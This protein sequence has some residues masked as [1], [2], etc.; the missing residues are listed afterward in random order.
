MKYLRGSEWVRWDL[1]I[2]TPCS[3]LNNQFG[4]DWDIYVR[5]L[6]NKAIENDIKVIGITDYF[7]IDGYKKLK[8]EY[9]NKDE[10]LKIIFENEIKEDPD[11][12]EKVKNIL[13]LPNIEFRLENEIYYSKDG[14]NVDNKKLQ[15]HIIFDNLVSIEN[16]EENFLQQLKFKAIATCRDGIDER[17]FTHNNLIELGQY[18][19][20]CQK[21]FEHMNDFQAGLNCAAV[22]LNT[23]INILEQNKNLFKNKYRLLVVEDDITNIKWGDQCHMTRKVIYSVAHGIFSSNQRT[24]DWGLAESTEKEFSSLKP[25]LWGSDAHNFDK[26]FNPDNMKYCWIKANPTFT[27]LMQVFYSPK[28][29]VFIGIEPPKLNVYNRNITQFIDRV[30]IRKKVGAINPEVWFSANMPFN[31]GLTAII[32]NKGSGKSALS[33][34]LGYLCNSKNMKFASFLNNER[35]RKENKLFSDDY[36]ANIKWQDGHNEYVSSLTP[37]KSQYEVQHAQ[38]LPQRYIENVCNNLD[39]EFQTEIDNVIFSYIDKKDRGNAHSLK[40]LIFERSSL[41]IAKIQDIKNQIENLN[42]KIMQLENKQTKIYRK[43]INDK[44]AYLQEE[45]KRTIENEPRK[46][47]KPNETNDSEF[48]TEIIRIE[49]LM[50]K[51]DQEIYYYNEQISSISSQIVDLKELHRQIDDFLEKYDQI[52]Q[53]IENARGIYSFSENELSIKLDI[54]FSGIDSKIEK[55]QKQKDDLNRL[56]SMIFDINSVNINMQ[57]TKNEIDKLV[58]KTYSLY[59][60]NAILLKYKI[61]LNNRTTVEQQKYQKYLDDYK[62]WQKKIE[63]IQKGSDMEQG[64]DWYNLEMEYVD[65]K[66]DTEIKLL[67]EK[68]LNLVLD[69]YNQIRETVSLYKDIYS[70]VQEKLQAILHDIDDQITFSTDIVTINNLGNQVLNYINQRVS[71]DFQGIA[72]GTSFIDQ[73]IRSTD[74]NNSDSL[75]TFVNQIY[76]ATT[77]D[78]DKID[79]L[80]KERLQFNNFISSLSY[81]K[82][83]YTLKMGQKSLNELSPGERGIVLLVFYLALEKS[84]CPL[85][86]DQPEDNLDNE[87][88]FTKLVPCICKAKTNRQVI[89]VTHNPNI[90][91]ACDA[92]QIIFCSIDKANNKIN[93]I[94]GGIEDSQIRNKVIEILEGTEPAF[95][96]RKL[97]YSI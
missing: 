10:K 36:E 76:N 59:E 52:K 45:L 5:K 14:K 90:A 57:T 20:K 80:L 13:L 93:Y 60:K 48:A 67:Y 6:F 15:Y 7:T 89:I 82:V 94:S 71:S 55:L 30:S 65:G 68:R 51:H 3:A 87:S 31:I 79:S 46:V 44:L 12:L 74:F 78:I 37:E 34:I 40:E 19:K 70:P 16:I 56:V 53:R 64:I 86:I 21:E 61:L 35:F 95:N 73:I 9:L 77:N 23:I 58:E 63:T 85:I 49:K 28:E 66:L 88:V 62:A 4:H 24:I 25:C 96:L 1:H 43:T 92:E 32:G 91:V 81:L 8:N 50:E 17:P 54:K 83:D 2:H 41:T 75:K 22:S 26:L 47:E 29:R 33:D 69:I 38:Y 39:N 97:K 42:L 72:K 27:G 18:V 84:D 11:Y